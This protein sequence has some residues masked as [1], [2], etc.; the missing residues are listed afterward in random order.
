MKTSTSPDQAAPRRP[1]T[2]RGVAQKQTKRGTEVTSG[3][4][5][6]EADFTPEQLVDSLEGE[7]ASPAVGMHVE[8]LEDALDPDE[9]EEVADLEAAAAREPSTVEVE[10][11]GP[12]AQG[13]DEP[14]G[15]EEAEK[16][17]VEP[18]LG[19]LLTGMLAPEQESPDD[20]DLPDLDIEYVPTARGNEFVCSACFLIWN[21]HHLA[22][23]QRKVCRDCI[24]DWAPPA[25][26]VEAA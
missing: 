8:T 16:E 24:D 12:D 9:L 13:T 5:I 19:A 11:A 10:D 4:D 23:A 14:A 26:Q 25:R 7:I 6:D 2:R 17:D 21:L 22:D 18:D 3:L 15:D 1:R 20:R